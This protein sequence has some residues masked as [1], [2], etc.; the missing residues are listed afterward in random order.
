M[1]LSATAER[2]REI[3]QQLAL[4]QAAA[5]DV[6]DAVGFSNADFPHAFALLASENDAGLARLLLRYARQSGQRDDPEWA[7]QVRALAI[8]DQDDARRADAEAMF[9]TWQSDAI[10]A[11]RDA[12]RGRM[13]WHVESDDAI[14]VGG[15]GVPWELR[16]TLRAAAEPNTPKAAGAMRLP[17]DRLDRIRMRLVD[18]HAHCIDRHEA[19][20]EW[21]KAH[22]P[23]H[24]IDNPFDD[25]AGRAVSVSL[26]VLRPSVDSDRGLVAVNWKPPFDAEGVAIRELLKTKFGARWDAG[27]KQWLLEAAAAVAFAN[28][29]RDEMPHVQLTP[30]EIQANP[31]EIRYWQASAATDQTVVRLV[32]ERRDAV[33][34]STPRRNDDFVALMGKVGARWDAGMGGYVMPW[35]A[36]PEVVQRINDSSMLDGQCLLPALRSYQVRAARDAASAASAPPA[37]PRR[38]AASASDLPLGEEAARSRHLVKD[39]GYINIA[40][41]GAQSP[42]MVRVALEGWSP[43]R[44]LRGA[45]TG[46]L[47][48][49]AVTRQ[50]APTGQIFVMSGFDGRSFVFA[51][52]TAAGAFAVDHSPPADMAAMEATLS[53]LGLPMPPIPAEEQKTPAF[54]VAR[55]YPEF[56]PAAAHALD[57]PIEQA[58][59]AK[60]K[61]RGGLR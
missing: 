20:V 5:P 30:P 38:E 4:T 27:P 14:Y 46:W 45:P 22:M 15:V 44:E 32:A 58:V 24:R 56:F 49:E 11:D 39:V 21:L 1:D 41:L 9:A 12:L 26:T 25:D 51:N 35:P 55:E 8:S 17:A 29:V 53:R 47:L 61:P 50:G 60:A 36:L 40:N 57:L 28:V 3:A 2:V 34:L 54:A 13:L 23:T 48:K 42:Q 7:A 37:P 18:E 33:V 43:A 10:A 19:F 16:R 59:D 31:V 52:A 6:E